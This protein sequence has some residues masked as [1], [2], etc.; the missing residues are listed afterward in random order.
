MLSQIRQ[1][2]VH[3]AS[4]NDVHDL[5]DQ[6]TNVTYVNNAVGMRHDVALLHYILWDMYIEGVIRVSCL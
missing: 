2:L 3:A 4:D 5:L 1:Q 6:L